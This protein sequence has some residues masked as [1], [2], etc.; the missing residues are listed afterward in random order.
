V[1]CAGW[2]RLG[3]VVTQLDITETL[4][5]RQQVFGEF[6]QSL[7]SKGFGLIRPARFDAQAMIALEPESHGQGHVVFHV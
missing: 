7:D 1:Q 5:E 3:F 6:L 2:V 4:I